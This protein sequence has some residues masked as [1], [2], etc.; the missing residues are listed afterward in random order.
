MV[1]MAGEPSFAIIQ[2]TDGSSSGGIVKNLGLAIFLI[3]HVHPHLRYSVECVWYHKRPRA[4][5]TQ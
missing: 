3:R 5:K 4:R 1:I 2:S